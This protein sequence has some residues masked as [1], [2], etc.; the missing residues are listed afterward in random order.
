[1]QLADELLGA[2]DRAGARE[3]YGIPSDFALPLIDVIEGSE[4][5]PL[6]TLSRHVRGLEQK[7]GQG[8]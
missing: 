3:L 8:A 4:G 1:M 6:C 2:L 5:L 7:R